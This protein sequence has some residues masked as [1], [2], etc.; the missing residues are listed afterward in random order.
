MDMATTF[1]ET[2][3]T[4]LF[5]VHTGLSVDE[6]AE[7]WLY[8]DGQIPVYATGLSYESLSWDLNLD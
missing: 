2:V 5:P 6:L 1:L 8:F 3:D 7:A 4:R